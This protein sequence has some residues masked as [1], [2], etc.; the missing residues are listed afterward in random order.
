MNAYNLVNIVNITQSTC[1]LGVVGVDVLYIA[2]QRFKWPD[3]VVE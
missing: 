3:A 1:Q 2:G